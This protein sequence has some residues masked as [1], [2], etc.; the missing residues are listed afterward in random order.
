MSGSVPPVEGAPTPALI[1]EYTELIAPY[2]LPYDGLSARTAACPPEDQELYRAITDTFVSEGPWKG[3]VRR[4]HY[5]ELMD[6]AGRSAAD[7][8]GQFELT[9]PRAFGVQA[10]A[11][12]VATIFRPFQNEGVPH[13]DDRTT[14]FLTQFANKLA[15]G[16]PERHLR[17]GVNPT[18]YAKA[19]GKRS[20][21]MAREAGESQPWLAAKLNSLAEAIA[22]RTHLIDVISREPVAEVDDTNELRRSNNELFE[23]LRRLRRYSIKSA[24][25]E[26]KTSA[27]S[28]H[29]MF[30][31]RLR[32]ATLIEQEGSDIRLDQW[33]PMVMSAI[34]QH[35]QLGVVTE[36][37]PA[38]DITDIDFSN[39]GRIVF[40][41][42]R[43][44]L[45][46]DAAGAVPLRPFYEAAGKPVN[47]ESLRQF[48]LQKYFDLTVPIEVV[49]EVEKNTSR[50]LGER[51]PDASREQGRVFHDLLLPRVKILRQYRQP[52]ALDEL[53]LQEDRAQAQEQQPYPYPRVEHTKRLPK[54]YKASDTARQ[55]AAEHGITLKE[56]ETFVSR[57][58][59][60][61][62]IAK[63]VQYRARKRKTD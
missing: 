6:F 25:H 32:Q 3:L 37:T 21:L 61:E 33:S 58:E 15:L 20:L 36:M 46:G 13:M 53:Q 24:L 28:I 39:F 18:L 4:G 22:L 63:D 35:L 34:E 56:G 59:P 42:D 26:G 55:L 2:T 54:G 16:M 27:W 48:L 29:D 51:N 9:L 49:R 52:E 47:Y 43:G 11:S 31:Y 57:Y 7:L 44:E 38:K 50:M 17:T 8:A 10:L 40:M 62:S 41:D 30:N 12:V 60:D 23:E 45:F 1:R 5:G 14:Y 19:I